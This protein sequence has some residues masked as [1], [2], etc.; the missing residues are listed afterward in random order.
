MRIDRLD[1]YG[2]HPEPGERLGCTVRFTE[3]TDTDARGDIEM[4]AGDRM[5]ARM[6]RFSDHRFE[7]T[8]ASFWFM[9]YSEICTIAEERDEGTWVLTEPWRTAAMRELVM[10]RYLS[11]PE[12]AEYEAMTPKAA[13]SW[14]I[15][16][17][18]AKDAVRRWLWKRGHGPIWPIEV[19]LT[20]DAQGRPLVSAPGGRDLRISLA[21][22][23]PYA[24]CAVAE[25]EETGVDIEVVEDRSPEFERLVATDAE[26]E[27]VA[28][29]VAAG[30]DRDE[31]LTRL[32]TVKEAVGKA[33]GTG[34]QG[35]PR[36]L[37]VV[38]IEGPWSRIR[39]HWVRTT[40]E[41]EFVVSTVT[42]R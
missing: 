10:R 22:R 18:A 28:A 30:E 24:A 23:P 21:H 27:L 37:E 19:T 20:N 35:R 40:R 29:Q 15:G 41:G 11:G 9:L 6:E 42:R 32:W 1:L 2:P 8:D 25:G 3:I 5:W 38:E 4:V 17:I 31:V 39:D 12:R 26:K 34:L 16:R 33:L 13:R 14:L 36:D 7:T